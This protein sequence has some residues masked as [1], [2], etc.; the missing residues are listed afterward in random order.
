[1]VS[2]PL[3]GV[4]NGPHGSGW[5]EGLTHPSCHVRGEGSLLEGVFPEEEVCV[6]A[7]VAVQLVVWRCDVR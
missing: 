4:R 7:L 2:L 3:A 5:D 1:M 6:S